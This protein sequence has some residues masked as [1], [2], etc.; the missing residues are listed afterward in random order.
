MRLADRFAAAA[1]S[2]VTMR[3]EAQIGLSVVFLGGQ[4]D[5]EVEPRGTGFFVVD[6]RGC[7]LVTARHVVESARAAGGLW[8]RMESDGAAVSV[9]ISDFDSWFLSGTTDVA[10]RTFPVEQLGDHRGVGLDWFATDDWLSEN[11]VG[12][13]DDVFFVGLFSPLASQERVAPITRFGNISL[14]PGEPVPIRTPDGST[15]RVEAWLVEARSWGGQS[16]SPAFIWLQP[17][18]YPGVFVVPSFDGDPGQG[19]VIAQ[20]DQVHLLGLVVGH[21]DLRQDVAFVPD[22]LEGSVGANTGIAVVIPAKEIA[23]AI[24]QLLETM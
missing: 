13:G 1:Y 18:R 21:F 17:M 24:D 22:A 14:P 5:G 8:A 9:D 15:V 16:G 10:V 12:P 11:W 4:R 3:I 6:E 7:F 20:K 19:G 2:G 23:M